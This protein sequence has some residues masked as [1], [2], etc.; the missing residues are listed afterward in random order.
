[1]IGIVIGLGVIGIVVIGVFI[2]NDLE[3]FNRFLEE[4][5]VEIFDYVGVYNGFLGYYYYIE[6]YD[7]LENMVFFYDDEK[8]VGIMVDGFLIYGRREMDGLYFIDLDEFGG[9]FGVI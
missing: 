3:G 8:L 1:M 4:M 5:I 2:F 9:Y 7:V 6:F